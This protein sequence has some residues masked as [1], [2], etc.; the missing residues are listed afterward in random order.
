MPK[1]SN[2]FQ[3]LIYLIENVLNDGNAKV[4]QSAEVID[5]DT[6]NIREV[7]ILIESIIGTHNVNIGIECVSKNRPADVKWIEEMS[8]KHE[9]LGTNKIILVSKLGFTKNA[10]T[11]ASK[12]NIEIHTLEDAEKIDWKA[13]VH[14]IPRITLCNFLIKGKKVIVVPLFNKNNSEKKEEDLDKAIIFGHKGENLG[15]MMSYSDIIVNE[16]LNSYQIGDEMEVGYDYEIPFEKRFHAPCYILDKHNNKI[17]I[18]MLKIILT[19]EKIIS[20]M[21]L[22]KQFYGNTPVTYA[23]TEFM[24]NKLNVTFIQKPDETIYF[25]GGIEKSKKS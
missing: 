10:M 11:K 3:K 14:K 12:L 18:Q 17:E 21:K 7:D 19:I 22:E 24:G 6:G 15:S 5:N 9:S 1:R 23:N 2:D 4:I 20:D 13:K 8:R 25:T 16:F